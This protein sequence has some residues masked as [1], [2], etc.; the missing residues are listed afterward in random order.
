MDKKLQ[1]VFESDAYADL[2]GDYMQAG[3]EFAIGFLHLTSPT[4][5]RE[6]TLV[7][8]ME[9][10][11]DAVNSSVLD[12]LPDSPQIGT[13]NAMGEIQ[14]ET[15]FYAKVSPAQPPADLNSPARPI[16][17]P[18]PIPSAAGTQRCGYCDAYVTVDASAPNGIRAIGG[19]CEFCKPSKPLHRGKADVQFDDDDVAVVYGIGTEYTI[20]AFNHKGTTY[21]IRRGE[22]AGDKHPFKTYVNGSEAGRY[23]GLADAI[24]RLAFMVDGK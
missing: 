12:V 6:S 15:I 18:A 4:A 21:S 7:G 16:P 22:S 5:L 14:S 2:L 24:E 8:V 1:A 11:G 13:L 19:G 10:A 17:S 20:V 9:K 3:R 23:Q